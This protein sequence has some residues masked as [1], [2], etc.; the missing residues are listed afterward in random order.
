MFF[1]LS[2]INFATELKRKSFL[3]LLAIKNLRRNSGGGSTLVQHEINQGDPHDEHIHKEA[4][5]NY[6]NMSV[7]ASNETICVKVQERK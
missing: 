1:L 6:L 2:K 5:R 4:K 3:L 7:V